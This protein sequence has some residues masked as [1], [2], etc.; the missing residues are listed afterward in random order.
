MRVCFQDSELM[1]VDSKS[2]SKLNLNVKLSRI[3]IIIAKPAI[4]PLLH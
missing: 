1:A 2:R 3:I 4:E